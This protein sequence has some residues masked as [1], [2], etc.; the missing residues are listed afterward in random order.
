MAIAGLAHPAGAGEMRVVNE[1]GTLRFGN[2]IDPEHDAH[3]LTPLRIVSCRV[4]QAPIGRA[5]LFV[6]GGHVGT[7]RR[8]V[9]EWNDA[10]VSVSHPR[11]K[12]AVKATG[13]YTIMDALD[14]PGEAMAPG[15]ETDSRSRSAVSSEKLGRVDVEDSGQLFEHIDGRGVLFAF[16]HSNI[17]AVDPGT[18]RKLLLRQAAVVPQLAQ[19]CRNDLPQGHAGTSPLYL[20][21]CHPV[22]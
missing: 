7:A 13:P 15:I 16:E 1:A 20:L 14:A 19:I 3:N 11:W 2:G 6:I 8:A 21:Y 9:V 4:E 12:N 18:I 10:H 22:Y 5:M 17:V